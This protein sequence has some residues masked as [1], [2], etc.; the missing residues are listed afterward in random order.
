MALVIP[1]CFLA[2]S[3]RDGCART[4]LGTSTS[5]HSPFFGQFT[6][7]SVVVRQIELLNFSSRFSLE[8]TS[9]CGF[10]F[11]RAFIFA[12]SAAGGGT[13]G[14]NPSETI[15]VLDIGVRVDKIPR[16]MREKRVISVRIHHSKRPHRCSILN[17]SRAII[18]GAEILGIKRSVQEMCTD[19]RASALA[20]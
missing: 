13:E 17:S 4:L 20:G 3:A 1:T 15:K 19:F 14:E 11:I 2:L 18:H 6:A 8:V 16:S 9:A 10:T 12:F 7:A 5:P